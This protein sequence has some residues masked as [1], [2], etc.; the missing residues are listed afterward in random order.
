MVLLSR[1]PAKL[2]RI[3]DQLLQDYAKHGAKVYIVQ[4]D[5]G[6][7]ADTRRA[8]RQALEMLGGKLDF[9]VNNGPGY[10]WQVGGV[11]FNSYMLTR[12]T[13]DDASWGRRCM[14]SGRVYHQQ[15]CD[16]G[17]HCRVP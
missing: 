11:A 5:L 17:K 15:R 4:V 13:A 2:A 8:M 10:N 6:K 12:R 7:P 14:P 16:H 1:D 3:R 9:L